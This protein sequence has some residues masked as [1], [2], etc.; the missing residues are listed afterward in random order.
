MTTNPDVRLRFRVLKTRGGWAGFVTGPEGLRRCYL[1]E[2]SEDALRARV[3]ADHPEARENARL[4]PALAAQLRDYLRGRPVEFD[5]TIDWE[6][7]GL[8]G[9][10]RRV[11]A[12]LLRTGRGET[13]TYGELARRAGRPGAARG[14]GTAMARN[15]YPPIVPCHRVLGSDGSLRGYSGPGGL[16]LKTRLLEIEGS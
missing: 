11:Y 5:V 13:L 2:A 1:P 12:E 6:G 10:Q 9:F 7:S 14:V 16:A 8:T 4:E 3:A 15:P